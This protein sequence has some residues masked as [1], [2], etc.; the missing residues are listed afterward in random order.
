MYDQW[1]TRCPNITTCFVHIREGN[2]STSLL[3]LPNICYFE[4]KQGTYQ[5]SDAIRLSLLSKFILIIFTI[6]SF[7]HSQKETLCRIRENSTWRV[8]EQRV[9]FQQFLR[10][11]II[12]IHCK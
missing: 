9:L 6:L 5:F 4:G 7:Y 10:K 3:K 12:I 1:T 8:Y 2:Y 11:S